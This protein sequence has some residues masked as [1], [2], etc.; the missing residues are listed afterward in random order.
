[1]EVKTVAVLGAGTMGNGIAQVFAQSG[2]DVKLIDIKKEFVDRGV[3]A[4]GKSLDRLIKK[5]R[6]TA[7]DKTAILGRIKTSTD[8]GDA[9]GSGNG[10]D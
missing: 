10:P 3:A 6:I 1:M 8:V 5:E 9:K 4:V 2:V 7:N